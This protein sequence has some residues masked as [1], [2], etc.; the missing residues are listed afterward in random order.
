LAQ[1]VEQ[2]DHQTAGHCER[3]AFIG[4]AMGRA[5]GLDNAQLLT[6]YRRGYLHDIGKVTIP[7]SIL[8]KPGNLTPPEWVTMR[9]HAAR[10]E[11]ICRPLESLKPGLPI[12]RHH[13]EHWD[14]G[15]YPDGL[16]GDQIP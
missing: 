4:F 10:G 12:I 16:R 8:F 3:L 2:H 6:I 9:S 13:H 7:D 1:A 14:G 15:G 11:D 5:L